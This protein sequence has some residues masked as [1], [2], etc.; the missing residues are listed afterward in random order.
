MKEKIIITIL[1]VIFLAILSG[2]IW[3]LYGRQLLYNTKN[4]PTNTNVQ[5][6]TMPTSVASVT[7]N[8]KTSGGSQTS[9]PGNKVD[10][11]ISYSSYSTCIENTKDLGSSKD[12]CDCMTADEP[13]RKACRDFAAT[14][15]FS[16]NTTFK[17]FE[18]PSKLGRNGDYSKFTVSGNQQQCKQVCESA[19]SGLV[20]GDYQYCRTACD[21]LSK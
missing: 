20:C 5:I 4:I 1:A 13:V 18:I 11:S 2:M 16:K 14:Y 3:D 21:N 9:V 8:Q 19:S 10:S 7:V 6:T 17:T 15:D 12:C